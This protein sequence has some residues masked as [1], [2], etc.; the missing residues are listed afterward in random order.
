MSIQQH[1]NDIINKVQDIKDEKILDEIDLLLNG[2]YIVA[3]TIGGKPLTKSDY[4]NH[5]VSISNSIANGAT[6]F[7]SE[8]VRNFILSKK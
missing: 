4:E 2:N 5:I 1:K 3:Y 8:E 7:S 6:T